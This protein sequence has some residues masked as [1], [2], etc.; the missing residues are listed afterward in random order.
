[1]KKRTL[2][3]V[4]L[5]ILFSLVLLNLHVMAKTQ[6][7][8]KMEKDGS[9][10]LPS[11][12]TKTHAASSFTQAPL[13][14]PDWKAFFD[15]NG[16]WTVLIDKATLTPH[17]AFGKPV[18]INNFD[19]ITDDNV[20]SASMQFLRDNSKILN[21]NPDNLIL[22]KS[23]KVNKLWYVGYKQVY[24]GIEVLLSEV[25]LRIRDDGKVI[26][27]G[28]E[29]YNNINVSI[30]PTVPLATAMTN[31]Y[32]GLKFDSKKD[33]TQSEGKMFILPVKNN[34]KVRFSLVYD[35]KVETSEPLG[36][37][38]SFVD[39][40]SGI[41]IWRLNKVQDVNTTVNVKGWIK[42][43]YSYDS[44]KLRPFPHQYFNIGTERNESNENGE[45]SKDIS[46]Q[47]SIIARMQG[48]WAKVQYSL[49]FN[50]STRDSAYFDA[51]LHPGDNFQLIWND[52]NSENYERILFYHT[53]Y[54]HDY[55]KNLD[56]LFTGMDLQINVTIIP[57]G[58]SP[59]AMSDGQDIM[60]I[61][62][63]LPDYK[64]AETPSILYHEY[65]HSVNAKLYIANGG[66]GRLGM[67][68][69]ACNEATAD[70]GSALMI[71]DEMIG[72]GAFA[73]DRNKNI[74][75][76]E[77][78]NIY[79]DS[80]EGES[81][82]DSQILSGAFWDFRKTT[83]REIAEQISHFSKYGT[84]DDPDDGISFNE[85]FLEAILTDDNIGTGDNDPSNG[86]PHLTELVTA[87]NEHQIGTDLLMAMSYNHTAISDTKNVVDPYIVEFNLKSEPNI[88]NSHPDS[89]FVVYS[90]DS[91]KN[92][93][94]V[95][96]I[97]M[98]SDSNKYR[99]EIPAMQN[100]T[101]VKYYI[102]A[103]ESVSG[104]TFKFTGAYPDFEPYQFLVGYETLY[105]EEFE[106][107]N[108]WTVVDQSDNATKGKWE[109]AVPKE[110]SEYSPNADKVLQPGEDHSIN[111]TR[112]FVTGA[113]VSVDGPIQNIYD[114]ISALENMP[115]GTT[116]LTSKIYDLSKVDKP[117]IR[118]YKYFSNELWLSSDPDNESIF[119]FSISSNGGSSWTQIDTMINSTWSWYKSLV[120]IENYIQI[121]NRMR[122]KFTV[123]PQTNIQ[124]IPYAIT[125]AL[126]DDFEI[127]YPGNVAPPTVAAD[128]AGTP[129]TG[130]APLSVQFSDS[131]KGNVATR[132][133]DFGDGTNSSEPNPEHVYN[134]KGKYNVSLTVS[135]GTNYDTKTKNE[136]I[137][138]S[139]LKAE[140]TVDKVAGIKP[141]VV[142]FTDKSVS[143]SELEWSW[144]FGDG[145][146]STEQNPTHT[147]NDE[148]I[149][150]VRLLIKHLND[151]S[152]INK[153]DLISVYEA[154]GASFTTD[155]TTG[156]IPL[157][158]NFTDNS[159]GSPTT[160]SWDFGD[161]TTSTEQNPS[162]IYTVQG[163][164]NVSLTVSDGNQQSTKT[165]VDFISAYRNTAVDD[166]SDGLIGLNVYP[167]PFSTS[168][169][170]YYELLSPAHVSLRIY[171][172]MG[173]VVSSLVDESQA[174]G[175]R[176]A[177][178]NGFKNDGTKANTGL[179][180]YRFK[181]GSKTFTG[182][183][184]LY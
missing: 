26:A 182:K 136:F 161:G 145:E 100:G 120:N 147:Y 106:I 127:L 183:L 125:E 175:R 49:D 173:N 25:E 7:N 59:N 27:F 164:Y 177:V 179:Y 93:N 95:S 36:K 103:K 96:A 44:A 113:Q 89:V 168:T 181:A 134:N 3:F 31:A 12:R 91:F 116:T 8:F 37:Y 21:I 9:I 19:N 54:I 112:C 109:R 101:I 77:N 176:V 102:Q 171:D 56:P 41:V 88:L 99:A 22:T 159:F 139:S 97:K 132:W 90:T 24:Q 111:G 16:N 118:Y 126:V 85:W 52:N 71:D 5:T 104:R 81:H 11:Q 163:I 45:W 94:K 63:D 14:S 138:V 105:L 60:F 83:S 40:H 149:Y 131:S 180:F 114:I 4:S 72:R 76:L 153:E 51:S 17:R 62:T 165:R 65:T 162:H 33:V 148:G 20:Q 142:Q 122:F 121:T 6:P 64:F 160:W 123:K 107:D 124:G 80:I 53:N 130:V 48:E 34:G 172:L 178:W 15:A 129:T 115:N 154:F 144:D 67:V 108:N 66:S 166:E 84:P 141:L 78:I 39:A 92:L 79:P 35:I 174:D 117:L 167:N 30:T 119:I 43:K 170:I 169:A 18:N 140:F 50:Q 150:S 70:I 13:R 156:V 61:S 75:N 46:S 110:E 57:D 135:D 38:N 2:V 1:M 58:Q 155:K 152:E 29:Y 74:R 158:I 47:K 133:W 69:G 28:V 23:K 184:I 98:L 68:N 143:I 82:H 86:T 151:S 146:T 157:T 32:S 73:E 137:N 10:L 128:F 55:L 42:E 87:F